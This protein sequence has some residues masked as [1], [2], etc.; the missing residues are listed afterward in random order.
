[1][2]AGSDQDASDANLET[3]PRTSVRNLP[4][5]NAMRGNEEVQSLRGLQRTI[6]RRF[7]NTA[8]VEVRWNT[9]LLGR[10][11]HDE[12]KVSRLVLGAVKDSANS[13]VVGNSSITRLGEELSV[14]RGY[15]WATHAAGVRSGRRWIG[16]SAN[17]GRTAAK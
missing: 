11:D 5:P 6:L 12:I 3:D 9:A 8:A 15:G 10:V 2:S 1:M 16:R 7:S 4:I 17:P 13:C 14:T